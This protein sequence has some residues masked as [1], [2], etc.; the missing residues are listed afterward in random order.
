ML[1]NPE[2]ADSAEETALEEEEDS[3]SPISDKKKVSSNRD[4]FFIELSMV[5]L[6]GIGPPASWTA[7]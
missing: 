7:P 5:S 3:N 4:L 6:G 1:T 2:E